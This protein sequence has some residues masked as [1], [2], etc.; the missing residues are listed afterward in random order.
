MRVDASVAA[1]VVP[2]LVNTET[3]RVVPAWQWASQPFHWERKRVRAAHESLAAEFAELVA[4]M[5]DENGS[6]VRDFSDDATGQHEICE[7]ENEYD[8]P[9]FCRVSVLDVNI[10]LP[11][12]DDCSC[13]PPHVQFMC[14]L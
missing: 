3:V 12:Y 4:D 10:M 6:L 8:P 5:A 7:E 1:A 9:S 11:V 13:H 14:Y 2:Q